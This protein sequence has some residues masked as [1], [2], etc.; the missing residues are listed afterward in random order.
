MWPSDG[1]LLG[2]NPRDRRSDAPVHSVTLRRADLVKTLRDKA[3]A[4]G[5]RP[6]TTT[7]L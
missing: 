2:E 4:V 5:A 1:R 3:I 6:A 7:A